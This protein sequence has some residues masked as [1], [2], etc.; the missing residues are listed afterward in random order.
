MMNYQKIRNV[1]T[2]YYGT[3]GS[4]G[5]DFFIPEDLGWNTKTIRPGT[6]ETIPSGIKLELPKGTC[7]IMLSRSSMG[8]LGLAVSAPLIDEDYRGEIHLIVTNSSDKEIVIRAGQKIIQGVITI[9]NQ[10]KL[11][12]SII[13]DNT[14][15]GSKR[16]G[17]TGADS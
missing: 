12:E 17:S 8:K 3:E 7:M 15:R 11:N 14:D 10:Y 13:E 1:K 9:Y 16:F 2:P 4:A 5:L 6:T